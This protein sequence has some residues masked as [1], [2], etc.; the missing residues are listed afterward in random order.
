MY[1]LL[2]KILTLENK[3]LNSLATIYLRPKNLKLINVF[4]SCNAFD[5]M[6]LGKVHIFLHWFCQL[7]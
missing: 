3:I 5:K 4:I 6:C 2:L 7:L 1:V